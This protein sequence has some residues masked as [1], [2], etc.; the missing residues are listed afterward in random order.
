MQLAAL[1][2]R[3]EA[4]FPTWVGFCHNDLQYGN[5][6]LLRGAGASSAGASNGTTGSSGSD[7][8]QA[9]AAAAAAG[10][11]GSGG[12]GGGGGDAAHSVTLIDYEYS[13]LNDVAFDV[14]NHFC[15]WAYDYHGGAPRR[16]CL[17]GWL[18]GRLLPGWRRA[19]SCHAG[20]CSRPPLPD[21][22][23]E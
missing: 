6:L 15:E 16:C 7:G 13:T 11:P 1:Q 2:A 18:A 14:A 4:S 9:A 5:M 17:A 21:P 19:G 23:S 8:Q 10:S 22:P 12:G 20:C 3:L